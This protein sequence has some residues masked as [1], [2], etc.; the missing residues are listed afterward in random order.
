[1][2]LVINKV[3]TN[4]LGDYASNLLNFSKRKM[5]DNYIKDKICKEVNNQSL[6]IGDDVFPD[7]EPMNVGNL[8][9]ELEK[10]TDDE[11]KN[12]IGEDKTIIY[13]LD[14][15]D[16]SYIKNNLSSPVCKVLRKGE[17]FSTMAKINNLSVLLFKVYGDP[18]VYGI[19]F[20]ASNGGIR[21]LIQVTI[22]SKKSIKK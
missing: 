3:S 6:C 15:N 11:I 10:L 8:L 21:K 4:E 13:T 16:L 9:I 20:P 12:Y 14:E 17:G 1:M 2:F 19:S 5:E 7:H 18:V 22:P